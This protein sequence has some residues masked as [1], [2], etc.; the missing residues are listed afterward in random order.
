[1][2][3]Q[4]NFKHITVNPGED[5]DIIIQAGA[6]R[7]EQPLSQKDVLSDSQHS[8]SDECD[9]MPDKE[10]SAM[11]EGM[12]A[13]KNAYHSTTLEDIESSKMS[14]TQIVV[15]AIAL[16]ALGSFILWYLVFS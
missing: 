2:A 7:D 13:S 3:D 11:H 12:F 4:T 1:M 10:V 15:I 16:I 5:D 6:P 8:A 14:K 9:I